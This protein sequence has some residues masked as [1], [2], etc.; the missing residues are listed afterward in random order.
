M[1]KQKKREK[2]EKEENLGQ[3]STSIILLKTTE[4]KFGHNISAS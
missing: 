3:K 1:R 2:G 4:N